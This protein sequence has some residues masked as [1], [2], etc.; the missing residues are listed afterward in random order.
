MNKRDVFLVVGGD[1]RQTYLAEILAEKGKVYTLGLDKNFLSKKTIPLQT[2]D[3]MT[4]SVNYLILP[5]PV[6]NDGVN[7]NTPLYDEKVSIYSLI[8]LLKHNAVVFGGKV[9]KESSIFTYKGFEVIDYLEREE[10]TVLNAVPMALSK[11]PIF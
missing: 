2:I 9:G 5:L 11:L 3:D 6:T 10:L 7:V 4:E 1:L 8:P